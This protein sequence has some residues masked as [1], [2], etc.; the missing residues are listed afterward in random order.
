MNTELKQISDDL[1]FIKSELAKIRDIMPDKE[2]FLTSEESRLLDN[3]F[4]NEKNKKLV[5]SKD[6][7]KSL[8]I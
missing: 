8:G 5:S 3:S 6:L 1:I 2:L 4:S 7:R